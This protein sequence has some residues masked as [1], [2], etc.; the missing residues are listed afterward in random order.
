MKVL[1]Q[2]K[3]ASEHESSENYLI[4]HMHNLINWWSH[5]QVYKVRFLFSPCIRKVGP[6][7]LQEIS[8]STA[9]FFP[10]AWGFRGDGCCF[11]IT[12]PPFVSAD[13]ISA[14][15]V[16]M[17]Y[18]LYEGEKSSR[19]NP[20][21]LIS[22]FIFLLLTPFSDWGQLFEAS[23]SV[24]HLHVLT[25][26]SDCGSVRQKKKKIRPLLYWGMVSHVDPKGL[27]NVLKHGV[28]AS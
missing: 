8:N 12:G 1:L 24:S 7:Y 23:G 21:G 2:S 27:T 5:H 18:V 26:G 22:S 25:W 3:H 13:N 17:A 15:W 14:S 9:F 28:T 10:R 16:W 20:V 6:F 11:L 4:L 19:S